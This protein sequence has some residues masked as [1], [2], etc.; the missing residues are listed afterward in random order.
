M[1]I[2]HTS[3]YIFCGND[4]NLFNNQDLCHLLIASFFRTTFI[5]D[6]A[7]F[8]QEEIKHWSLLL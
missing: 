6:W 3:P 1:Y 2:L 8:L 5:F 7:V 4:E